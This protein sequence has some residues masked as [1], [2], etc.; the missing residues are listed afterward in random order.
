MLGKQTLERAMSSHASEVCPCD[1]KRKQQAARPGSFAATATLKQAPKPAQM[2]AQM[3][4]MPP[5]VGA[6][7]TAKAWA[8]G[9]HPQQ[10]LELLECVAII[11]R[12][13]RRARALEQARQRRGN[14]RARSPPMPK[15]S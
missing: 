5:W 15:V 2:Q 1:T 12:Q 10:A 6:G 3:Q 14:V 7:A 13:A 8:A 9:C 11:Q 4:T